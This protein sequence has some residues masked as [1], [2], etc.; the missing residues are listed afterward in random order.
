MKLSTQFPDMTTREGRKQ[1][2]EEYNYLELL[3]WPVVAFLGIPVLLLLM[4]AVDYFATKG[5]W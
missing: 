3:V 4:A 2:R 1:A 5:G